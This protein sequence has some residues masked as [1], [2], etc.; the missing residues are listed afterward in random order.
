MLNGRGSSAVPVAKRF[1]ATVRRVFQSWLEGA[2]GSSGG[3]AVSFE[4]GGAGS[5]AFVGS[6]AAGGSSL[7]TFSSGGSAFGLS[8]SSPGSG[9]ACFA[10]GGGALFTGAAAP[11]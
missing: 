5:G 8:Y 4:V 9:R 1:Q 2:C 6:V 3:G 11:L 7:T 10:T